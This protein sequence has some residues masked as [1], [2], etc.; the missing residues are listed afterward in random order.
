MQYFRQPFARLWQNFSDAPY[1]V[2]IE[3]VLRIYV[4]ALY[5]SRRQTAGV[6]EATL[7]FVDDERTV[8]T[9]EDGVPN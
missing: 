1:T 4:D 9:R 6:A 2:T 7:R 5:L 3:E 8:Q